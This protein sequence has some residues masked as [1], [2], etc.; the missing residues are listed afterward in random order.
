[1]LCQQ[2]GARF[3]ALSPA[4]RREEQIDYMLKRSR[5]T[6]W[7]PK[8]YERQAE[9]AGA[10]Q[11]QGRWFRSWHRCSNK[12]IRKI[13]TIVNIRIELLIRWTKLR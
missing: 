4:F 3:R 2:S 8:G 13:G 6:P 5:Q 12:W 1:M 11:Q 7:P 9:Q 10:E